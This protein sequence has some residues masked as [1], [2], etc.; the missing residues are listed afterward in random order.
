MERG[1][2]SGPRHSLAKRPRRAAARDSSLEVGA[3]GADQGPDGRGQSPTVTAGAAV[4]PEV[5]DR[6]E[7]TSTEPAGVGIT[8]APV[9]DYHVPDNPLTGATP[10]RPEAPRQM[11]SLFTAHQASVNNRAWPLD[12]H[13][14]G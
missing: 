7:A 10:P 2:D 4:P 12:L 8:T 1:S 6:R 13:R 9:H 11:R 3:D 14:C 5:G